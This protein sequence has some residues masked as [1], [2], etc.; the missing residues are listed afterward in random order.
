MIIHNTYG[1]SQAA[2][3][4]T[5]AAGGP[6]PPPKNVESR[7]PS[8]AQLAEATAQEPSAARLRQAVDGI[9]QAMRS[10]SSNLTFSIDPDTQH[11]VVK[12]IDTETGEVIRQV[13]P[14]V[15][16]GIAAQIDQELANRKGLLLS[17]A[18]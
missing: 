13:P 2:L 10:M 14:K 15:A 1:Q 5:R 9:N 11:V 7:A 17:G 16:L 12:V 6:A 3:P 8:P 18:A 4:D